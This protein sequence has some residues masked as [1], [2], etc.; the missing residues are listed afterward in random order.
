MPKVFCYTFTIF[1]DIM[2]TI[3]IDKELGKEQFRKDVPVHFTIHFEQTGGGG[4]ASLSGRN[5]R[6]TCSRSLGSL[7][8]RTILEVLIAGLLLVWICSQGLPVIRHQDA[9]HCLVHGYW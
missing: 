5:L 6:S 2:I 8:G 3:T 1:G 4:G 9:I 7:A